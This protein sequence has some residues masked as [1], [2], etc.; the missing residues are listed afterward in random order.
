M[1]SFCLY[2]CPASCNGCGITNFLTRVPGVRLT[3]QA[4][5]LGVPGVS[6]D[7]NRKYDQFVAN[8]RLKTRIFLA[9]FVLGSVI[10]MGFMWKVS[11]Q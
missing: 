9:A 1:Q 11:M 8:E 10:G 7:F 3:I 5:V 4:H 2:I 6:A